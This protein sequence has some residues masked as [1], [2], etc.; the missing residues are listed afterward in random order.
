MLNRI[1]HDAKSL[2]SRKQG[3]VNS[4]HQLFQYDLFFWFLPNIHRKKKYI[5]KICRAIWDI[6]LECFIV[7]EIVSVIAFGRNTVKKPSFEGNF[8]WTSERLSS[9]INIPFYLL[10]GQ[11]SA[12]L[13]HQESDVSVNVTW[14]DLPLWSK[15]PF[16][17][18][19]QGTTT[20]L[21]C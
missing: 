10:T 3:G 4:N 21:S 20:M 11:S 16:N 2:W 5:I 8:V 12:P 13:G 17:R 9:E 19:G 7:R 6:S 14:W 18:D 1:R 15:K